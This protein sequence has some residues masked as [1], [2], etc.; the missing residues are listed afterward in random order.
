[1][2]KSGSGS[3]WPHLPKLTSAGS[4]TQHPIRD[5]KHHSA[6]VD[7]LAG[8][9]PLIGLFHVL[10]DQGPTA[11]L[12]GDRHSAGSEKG[13]IKRSR[14]KG[15]RGELDPWTTDPPAAAR[16]VAPI[17]P[18]GDDWGGHT[19]G[20]AGE[21]DRLPW[22]GLDM[23][24]RGVD[25]L[26]RSWEREEE[27]LSQHTHSQVEKVQFF[28]PMPHKPL[29]LTATRNCHILLQAMTKKKD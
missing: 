26:W 14:G 27:Q 11:L 18:P 25:N 16:D 1:M 24:L 28:Y 7:G 9:S 23:F 4:K 19:S 20:Y 5:T 2:A 6:G 21:A 12:T 29:E 8:V 3:L 17:E 15:K 22:G 10:D 13:S